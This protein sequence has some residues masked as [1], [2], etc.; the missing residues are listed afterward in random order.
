MC[1]TPAPGA[2]H[3]PYTLGGNGASPKGLDKRTFLRTS[4]NC[5]WQKFAELFMGELQAL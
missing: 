4:Q 3:I 2:R 1:Q 5:V